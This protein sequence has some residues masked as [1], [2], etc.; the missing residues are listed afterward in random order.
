MIEPSDL[1]VYRSAVALLE[2]DPVN[3]NDLTIYERHAPEWWDPRSR[4]F[5]S[6]HQVTAFRLELL[7]SWMAEGFAGQTIYD[8][9]CGGGL[10]SE[11][12]AEAGARVVGIDLSGESLRVARAH[13]VRLL[14]GPAYV[15]ANVTRVPFPEASADGVLLADVLEHC[16]S[17][18]AVI[19]EAS[20]L[21]RPGGWLYVNTIN[22]TARARWVVVHL[23]ETVGLIPR[24]THDSRLFV[25]PDELQEFAE[26]ADL[27]RVARC[28]ETPRL[29]STVTRRAVTLRP[30]ASLAIAYSVLYRKA[31][32]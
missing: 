14:A 26:R 4:A 23:A 10:L 8:L 16:E 7:R 24:G 32:P 27:T 3:R 25:T 28:G 21:L 15:R 31:L 12:L 17:P 9:G 19:L 22:R 13:G 11:P 1:R 5:R 30:C 6:L 18:A 2:R 20:R 29:W